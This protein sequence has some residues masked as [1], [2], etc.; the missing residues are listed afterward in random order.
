M[1]QTTRRMKKI[2]LS[3]F[4]CA[5]SIAPF[6]QN[7]GIGTNT[8]SAKLHVAG[9]GINVIYGINNGFSGSG[10]IGESNAAGT[11][12]MK[13]LSNSGI[14]VYG[15]TITGTAV[16]GYGNNAGSVAVFGSAL[17]GTGV[18]AVSFTGTALEVA[19]NVRISGGN[20]NP[21]FGAVL[22]CDAEGNA[23]WKS[24]KIAFSARRDINQALPFSFARL[25]FD[26][27]F[28]AGNGFHSN[29]SATNPNIFVAPVSGFYY[30]SASAHL[31]ITSATTNIF[32]ATIL[33]GIVGASA[34]FTYGIA[35]QAING[36]NYST[37][38]VQAQ[39]G[40]HLTAGQKVEVLVY[41]N[42]TGNLPSVS[43]GNL[44]SGFLVFAD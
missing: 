33:I 44:F 42:N 20:T 38:F 25:I 37:A 4:I 3:I 2:I 11:Y 28:D 7:V 40:T 13:G 10:I 23:T 34:G 12:G 22:T 35:N 30:F 1:L 26:F 19:G 36:P 17:A 9:S 8:P 43:L 39:G 6:A 16:K 18:K 29:G 14:G 24:Q 27:A 21:S 5:I 41:A 31:K 15:E 32:D